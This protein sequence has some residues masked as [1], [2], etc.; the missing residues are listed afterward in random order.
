[1]PH[2]EPPRDHVELTWGKLSMAA[3]GRVAYFLITVIAVTLIG[4]FRQ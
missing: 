4:W 1:M 3:S 2:T